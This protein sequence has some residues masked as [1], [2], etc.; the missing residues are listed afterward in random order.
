LN[1]TKCRNISPRACVSEF[2]GMFTFLTFA[3]RSCYRRIVA[4]PKQ[5]AKRRNAEY[6]NAHQK[7]CVECKQ[8]KLIYARNMC[9]QVFGY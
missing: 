9:R 4:V 6:I 2:L 7:E 8:M 1:A 3:F 5:V